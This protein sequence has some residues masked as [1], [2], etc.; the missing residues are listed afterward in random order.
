MADSS[1]QDDTIVFKVT[2]MANET[3]PSVPG[4]AG[5]VQWQWAASSSSWMITCHSCQLTTL[6]VLLLLAVLMHA[7]A[8]RSTVCLHTF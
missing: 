5:H 6:L 4:I 2:L 7:A 3:H 8:R 1:A